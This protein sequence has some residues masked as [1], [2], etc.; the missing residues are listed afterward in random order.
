MAGTSDEDFA[1]KMLQIRGGKV[2]A[3]E[4]RRISNR[5]I[6]LTADDVYATV[7]DLSV[8]GCYSAVFDQRQM[9]EPL[10]RDLKKQ[11]YRLIEQDYTVTVAWNH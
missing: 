7:R 6:K 8:R 1:A 9:T 11:G 4:A 2:K 10:K 3:E 5:T